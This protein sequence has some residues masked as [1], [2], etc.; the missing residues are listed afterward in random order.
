METVL[1]TIALLTVAIT[2]TGFGGDPPGMGGG[3]DYW[4]E[5]RGSLNPDEWTKVALIFG[6]DNKQWNGVMC[7]AFVEAMRV[8]VSDA[9]APAQFRCVP[10]D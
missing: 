7:D 10:A 9:P 4:I 3:D 5:Q 8:K 6:Y 2:L 1:K